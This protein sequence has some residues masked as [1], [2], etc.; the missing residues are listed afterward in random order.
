MQSISS[1]QLLAVAAALLVLAAGI[2]WII[3]SHKREQDKTQARLQEIQ[4]KL[5]E[6]ENNKAN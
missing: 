4:D 1:A 2:F 6:I 5:K 3:K